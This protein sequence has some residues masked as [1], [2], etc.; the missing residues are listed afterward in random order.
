MDTLELITNEIVVRKIYAPVPKNDE[1][2]KTASRLVEM[3]A[4]IQFYNRDSKIGLCSDVTLNA[5]TSD[6]HDKGCFFAFVGKD[7]YTIYT[8]EYYLK[9]DFP[10][11]HLIK[12]VHFGKAF[13]DTSVEYKIPLTDN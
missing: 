9:Y 7:T 6:D 10:Y 1:D 11:D 2:R 5:V 13:E 12:G 3:D 8:S 4:D